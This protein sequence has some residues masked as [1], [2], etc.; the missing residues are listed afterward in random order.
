MASHFQEFHQDVKRKSA[1]VNP[2]FSALARLSKAVIEGD[3]GVSAASPRYVVSP[4]MNGGAAVA[5]EETFSEKGRRGFKREGLDNNG[6]DNNNFISDG[7]HHKGYAK[8][9]LQ[10]D[11]QA[12][13][14][15][16]DPYSEVTKGQSYLVKADSRSTV[17]QNRHA[18]DEAARQYE[19]EL[20]RD[21]TNVNVGKVMNLGS[22]GILVHWKN[23]GVDNIA[24]KSN[25]VSSTNRNVGKTIDVVNDREYGGDNHKSLA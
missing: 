17:H 19:A 14:L 18:S 10:A 24:V 4:D 20:N 16:S 6:L 3:R 5:S 12:S 15:L 13:T 23:H 7:Y 22:A 21:Y 1:P 25:Q 2:D 9:G 8:D 11:K